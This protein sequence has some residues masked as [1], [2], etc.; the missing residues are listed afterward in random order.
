[1]KLTPVCGWRLCFT[2]AKLFII[3]L[4]VV[5]GLGKGLD[6]RHVAE[7]L[8]CLFRVFSTVAVCIQLKRLVPSVEGI[9]WFGWRTL[10]RADGKVE[11][12]LT[13]VVSKEG[14]FLT[15]LHK[16]MNSQFQILVC[17]FEGRGG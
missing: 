5:V 9:E 6:Y 13:V 16:S 3:H 1:M 8:R 15:R 7:E 10:D 2:V 4:P 11:V 17:V 14:S 12:F